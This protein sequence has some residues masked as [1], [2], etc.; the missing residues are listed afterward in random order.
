MSQ[1]VVRN[2]GT[3]LI[4]EAVMG[5]LIEK[6]ELNV[7]GERFTTK[8]Q[9]L[10]ME[11]GVDQEIETGLPLSI[12]AQSERNSEINKQSLVT[13]FNNSRRSI[14]SK[15]GDIIEVLDEDSNEVKMRQY[16]E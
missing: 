4:N 13:N 12:T 8:T 14:V 11:S 9:K 16:S 2:Y 10:E 1:T 15:K 5:A 6:H 7:V 3:H